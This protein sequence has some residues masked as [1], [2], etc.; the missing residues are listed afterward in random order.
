M[1]ETLELNDTHRLVVS[2]DYWAD[3]ES[4]VGDSLGIYTLRTARGMS[5][6]TQGEFSEEFASLS[7]RVADSE[8]LKR[9]TGLWLTLKGW[10]WQVVDLSGYSQGEWAEV[11]VYGE[12]DLAPSIEAL[13]EFW[14]GDVYTV[15]LETK[16]TYTHDVYPSKKLEQWEAQDWLS[17]VIFTADYT[18]R[19]HASEYF[20][21]LMSK[22]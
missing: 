11:I 19:D 20:S 15:T 1:E 22:N 10:N 13:R 21:H 2:H 7:R 6:L 17:G 14:R 16:E 4:V 12:F 18:L 8:Q 3:L 5:Q 9:T